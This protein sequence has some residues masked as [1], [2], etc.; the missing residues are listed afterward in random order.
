MQYRQLGATGPM[1]SAIALGC[2]G[3]SDGYGPPRPAD[4]SE[5]IATIQAALDAGINLL[6]TGDFYGSSHNEMLVGEALKGRRRDQAILSVK[7]GV[8][9]D[10]DG[11]L[12]GFDNRPAALQR[13]PQTKF[14][15]RRLPQFQR[16][17]SYREPA[18]QSESC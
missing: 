4:R 1:V 13:T 12:K 5:C 2:M 14:A 16:T 7:F 11:G 3:M 15:G 10:P 9:R 8:L 17:V 6:D 18:Q